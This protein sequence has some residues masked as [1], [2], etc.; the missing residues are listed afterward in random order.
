MK[1]E[2]YFYFK[3]VIFNATFC[4]ALLNQQI[5]EQALISQKANG[6]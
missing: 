3:L 4:A 2:K 6:Y 5:I 1:I